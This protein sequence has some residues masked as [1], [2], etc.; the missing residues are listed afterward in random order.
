MLRPWGFDVGDITVPVA[1]W[2]GTQD[3]MVPFAHAEWLA[4]HVPGAR[5]PPGRG[6]GSHL[7]ADADAAILDDLLDLAG[8]A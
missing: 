8:R 2:Q 1:V 5:A 4:A 3:M 6:R 7:A